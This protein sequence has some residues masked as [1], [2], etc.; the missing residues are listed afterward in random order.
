MEPNFEDGIFLGVV[1][2]S[3]EMIVGTKE[4]HAVSCRDIKRHVDGKRTNKD[5]MN[6]LIGS[7]WQP[8]PGSEDDIE[9]AT[10]IGKSSLKEPEVPRLFVQEGMPEPRKYY[11]TQCLIEK[12]GK[13]P[14]CPKCEKN[15]EAQPGVHR[16]DH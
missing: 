12:F 3:L 10:K 11:V 6:K 9:P 4:G 1:E 8:K 2:R 13:T 15:T 14:G 5:L 7:P 16:K